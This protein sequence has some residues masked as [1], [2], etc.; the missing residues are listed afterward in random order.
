MSS[1]ESYIP[2]GLSSKDIEESS[3]EEDDYISMALPSITSSTKTIETSLQR[4]QRQKRE[5]EERAR[6]LSKADQAAKAADQRE[7]AL[8]TSLDPSNKGARMMAKLGFKGGALGKGREG[9]TEPISVQMRE[10]RGGIGIDE[11]RKR[12]LRDAADGRAKRVRLDELDYRERVRRE[13]EVKRLEALFHAAGKVAEGMEYGEVEGPDEGKS[14]GK[15][16]LESDDAKPKKTMRQPSELTPLLGVNVL[17]RGLVKHRRE[18]AYNRT[19]RHDLHQSSTRLPAYDDPDEHEQDA[20]AFGREEAEDLHEEDPELDDFNAL[21]L[22]ER[23]GR[24][25]HYLRVKHNYC[26]WC[27]FRY[28]G[29]EMDGCP[30]VT[31]EEHD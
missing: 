3:S 12:K 14:S 22:E 2:L 31:E 7:L 28:P 27:K 24:L 10:G 21:E 5:A 30:G 17:W 18:Q 6:P 1:P 26:F 20:L 11:D 8:A 16:T 25:V 4:R 13:R 23:L 19:I 9:R 15:D 29:P